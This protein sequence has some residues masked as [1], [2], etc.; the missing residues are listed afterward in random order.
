MLMGWSFITFYF[1]LTLSQPVN[2]LRLSFLHPLYG[3][4][5]AFYTC[6]PNGK[7]KKTTHVSILLK[8]YTI[9]PL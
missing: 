3:T 7:K 6:G 1:L 9:I 5:N 2:V 4:V 8:P